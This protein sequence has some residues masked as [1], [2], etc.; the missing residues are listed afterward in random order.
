MHL[1]IFMAN[2]A[3]FLRLFRK[4]ISI[5]DPHTHIRERETLGFVQEYSYR[6]SVLVL[7]AD[8]KTLT[9]M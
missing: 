7:A 8:G 3:I 6:F 1:V 9:S 4:F 5:L 2:I